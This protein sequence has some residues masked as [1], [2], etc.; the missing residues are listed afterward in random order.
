MENLGEMLTY[1]E[2][3]VELGISRPTLERWLV[4]RQIQTFRKI[5]DRRAYIRRSDVEALR[6]W[7]PREAKKDAA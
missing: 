4:A 7:Q 1:N 5:G 6:G 3:A 2:A